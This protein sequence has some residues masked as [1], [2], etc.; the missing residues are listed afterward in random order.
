M[1]TSPS[2]RNTSMLVKIFIIC[3]F[4]IYKRDALEYFKLKCILKNQI[5]LQA[6]LGKFI[7]K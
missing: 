3:F 7:K 6:I 4:L 2:A 5:R 1:K